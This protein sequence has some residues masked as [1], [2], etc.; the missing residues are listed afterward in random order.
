[1]KTIDTSTDWSGKL[2]S[3][4]EEYKN[5]SDK[6]KNELFEML[7]K[8]RENSEAKHEKELSVPELIEIWERV[9]SIIKDLKK[10]Y[11]KVEKAKV[12]WHK[13]KTVHINLPAVGGFEWFKFDWFFSRDK[14]QKKDF[15]SN[16]EYKEKSYSMEDISNLMKALR[17]YMKV[18]WASYEE[19]WNYY[20]D[21]KYR[22]NGVKGTYSQ[23]WDFLREITWMEYG[24][25][26][27]YWLKDVDD[28]LKNY[29]ACLDL[30]EAS[31]HFGRLGYN[32]AEANLLLRLSD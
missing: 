8:D 6:E 16:S 2:K 26:D 21:L 5:L 20:D 27:R 25:S 17:E 4:M 11:I 19:N 1:M 23:I 13:W 30:N 18:C 3:I 28:Y 15:E 29:R 14:V 22:N 31:F 9:D 24:I 12:M 7:M 32:V 10:N